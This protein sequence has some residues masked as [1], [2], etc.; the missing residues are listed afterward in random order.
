MPTATESEIR[1]ECRKRGWPCRKQ[2][3]NVG[4]LYED[5]AGRFC[6]QIRLHEGRLQ[7]RRVI[8]SRAVNY[9]SPEF[10]KPADVL[11]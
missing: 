10:V 9:G 5:H 1:I 2:W 8:L 6:Y 4:D 11:R 3:A 7:R